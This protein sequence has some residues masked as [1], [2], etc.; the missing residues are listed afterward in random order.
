MLCQS[1]DVS[2]RMG[3]FTWR[4]VFHMLTS[5][6]QIN[7]S[8]LE[9]SW[10]FETVTGRNYIVVWYSSVIRNTS[11]V[12]W[13]QQ[14]FS[15]DVTWVSGRKKETRTYLCYLDHSHEWNT[16]KTKYCS[17]FLR[18]GKQING[19][20]LLVGSAFSSVHTGSSIILSERNEYPSSAGPGKGR[21]YSSTLALQQHMWQ[22]GQTV[23]RC[24][25]RT[26]SQGKKK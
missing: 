26:C 11:K 21:T 4:S 1:S 7:I 17:H 25:S 18:N 5:A 16:N 22:V 23:G 6:P 24:P 12:Q 20:W 2:C 9:L 15:Y 19:W 3:L 8:P 13:V 10:D 14:W